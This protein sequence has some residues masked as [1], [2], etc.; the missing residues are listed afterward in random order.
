[1]V[2]Y[3]MKIL[4]LLWS[5]IKMVAKFSCISIFL[6]S[7]KVFGTKFWQLSLSLKEWKV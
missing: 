6:F 2:L 4:R 1:M 3:C 7:H 5:Q